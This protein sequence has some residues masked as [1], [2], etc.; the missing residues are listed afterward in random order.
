[1]AI[2]SVEHGI[3]R[4]GL[5]VVISSPSGAGKSTIARQLL[6]DADMNLSLSVSVTTRERRPS[7]I[8]GVHYHFITKREF[9]RRRDNDELIEWA[10]VHGNFYGTLRQTAEEALADGKD[11]LFDIDWQGAEQLQAKMPA[12]VVSIFILPPTMRELQNR[13][14]R[15]A[16]DTADVIETRLQNARFEIQKWAKYDYIVINE[17]LQRS[18]AGIKGIII[19]ERLRRDRRPGLFEFVEGLLEEN[20]EI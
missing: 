13:L 16:E 6:S 15:R 19:A 7:E 18:Y 2:S 11:M 9:E 17:D 12:D 1:M 3:A 4:R 8:E 20:P 10:E 14:N 5:M